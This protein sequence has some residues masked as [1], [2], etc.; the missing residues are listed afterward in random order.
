MTE[1]ASHSA[2]AEN[3]QARSLRRAGALL[4]RADI[5]N[6]HAWDARALAYDELEPDN[7]VR[8]LG[9][10]WA[11]TC[12]PLRVARS[13][14]FALARAAAAKQ[15]ASRLPAGIGDDARAVVRAALER[16]RDLSARYNGLC[17]GGST[18]RERCDCAAAM[19]RAEQIFETL[20][21]KFNAR[22][23]GATDAKAER[24]L[25]AQARAFEWQ[26]IA[27]Q[28]ERLSVW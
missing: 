9:D 19:E 5:A 23:I 15:R 4:A 26:E 12:A 6:A 3:G 21:D 2:T 14:Y 28:G 7:T 16:F 18:Y 27:A 13:T 24:D 22:V 8:K 20:R 1:F 11:A 25:T 17:E 10:E